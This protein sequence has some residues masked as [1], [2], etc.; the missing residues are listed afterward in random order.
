M[1]KSLLLSFLFVSN[2]NFSH[3][4]PAGCPTND[5][6]L[7]AAVNNGQRI[8]CQIKYFTGGKGGR[9]IKKPIYPNAQ[10]SIELACI[11]AQSQ[12]CP[13]IALCYESPYFECAPEKL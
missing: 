11:D 3:K 12:A 6:G 2:S 8:V 4:M 9:W 5:V 13:G 7:I 10:A 1:K